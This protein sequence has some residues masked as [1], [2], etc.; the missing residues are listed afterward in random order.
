VLGSI[1]A[2]DV[3]SSNLFVYDKE[4]ENWET[5]D[6]ELPANSTDLSVVLVNTNLHL[7]GRVA[8][9]QDTFHIRQRVIYRAQLPLVPR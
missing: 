1:Y 5:F 7:L 3:S 8:Q 6:I 4:S 9:E 2:F